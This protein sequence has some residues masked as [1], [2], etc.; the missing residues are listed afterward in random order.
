ML[1][2]AHLVTGAVIG[3]YVNDPWQIFILS[4]MM[5]FVLDML[6]HWDPKFVKNRSWFLKGSIDLLIGFLLCF[7]LLGGSL[8]ANTMLGMLSSILPD[9][10]TMM[11]VVG[12]LKQIDFLVKWHKKIQNKKSNI[13]GL[14]SQLVIVVLMSLAL[15]SG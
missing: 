15:I 13:W 12:G 7:W 14:F 11:I 6:P 3:K 9:V 4:V 5:H 2:T 1:S 10:M 8:N